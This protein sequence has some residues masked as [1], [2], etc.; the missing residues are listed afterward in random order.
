MTDLQRAQ[1][2]IAPQ[3]TQGG[4]E[5]QGRPGE[6]ASAVAERGK[7]VASAAK[8]GAGQTAGTAADSA[9]QVAASAA[10][11]AG[12]LTREASDQAR[13]LAEQA[14]QQV[15]EQVS[16]QTERAA[17]GL[18]DIS[19]QV[20]ALSEGQPEQAGFAADGAR[21]LAQ[22]IEQFATRVEQR[23]FDGTVEDVRQFARRRPALFLAG[24]AAA[25][26][27]VTRFGRG[28]QASAGH[29]A[30]AGGTGAPSSG[31]LAP[32]APAVSAPAQLPPHARPPA[33][34]PVGAT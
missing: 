10:E 29:P 26:F 14:Q 17:K 20:R 18:R 5:S 13:E 16:V 32:A 9:R 1:A 34:G 6:V 28:V 33:G 25:G 12:A 11:Q 19:E 27:A 2:P 31:D 24:A 8:E 22:R 3:S 7:N 21:Q 15:R 30:N 23:G 4:E